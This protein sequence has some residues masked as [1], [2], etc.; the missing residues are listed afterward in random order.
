[1]HAPGVP[2]ETVTVPESD[3]LHMTPLPAG[4]VK[5]R[6][7]VAIEP[8]TVTV[9]VSGRTPPVPSGF[10]KFT[11][12]VALAVHV[13]VGRREQLELRMLLFEADGQS[14]GAFPLVYWMVGLTSTDCA[15][16]L[17]P[18]PASGW[19]EG[20][21]GAASVPVETSGA[22]SVEPPASPPA[23]VE[24]ELLLHPACNAH[25]STRTIAEDS[26]SM[27]ASLNSSR[28]VG[29]AVASRNQ[30]HRRVSSIWVTGR[31]P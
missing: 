14:V 16:R 3:W 2:I 27:T 31:H 23:G 5:V 7:P 9:P 30:G 11:L 6:E 21:S 13:P 29:R 19:F 20:A 4:S 10:W 24:E 17:H 26:L 1:M 18:D 22:A 8:A 25:A 28:R 15:D 12:H